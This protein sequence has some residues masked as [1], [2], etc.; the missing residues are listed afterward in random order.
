[1]NTKHTFWSLCEKYDKIEVP[2][3]Q[4]DY[5]QGRE[6]LEA[7]RIRKKFINEY[8]LDSLIKKEKIELDFVYGSIQIAEK[9]ESKQTI[10]IP[11]DGQ[12]R[13]T[14]LFLLHWFVAIKENRLDDAKTNLL[15]FNYET[16]PSAHDFCTKLIE[17]CNIKNL[18]KV[19]QEILDSEWYD[20]EWDNDP[21]I[22]GMIT[23][24][25]TFSKNE[26]FIN[27]SDKFYDSLIG[28]NDGLI[29]FYFI[30]LEEFGLTENLY[31][32]MNARGKM[33]TEF[34]SFKSEFYKII[35]PFPE[36]LEEIKDKIEYAWVENLWA[37]KEK[38]SYVVDKPFMQFLS[39]LTEMLYFKSAK[40]RADSYESDFLDF[41]VLKQIYSKKDNLKFLVFSLDAIKTISELNQ[42]NILWIEKSTIHDILNSILA[43]KRDI[44]QL[45][46]LY[47]TLTYLFQGKNVEYLNDFIRVIRNLIENTTDNSRREWPKLLKSTNNLIQ[48]RNVYEILLDEKINDSLDGFY[49]PQR[50]EEIL[51]A[52]IISSFPAVKELLFSIEDNDI[53]KGNIAMLIAANYVSSESDLADFD[54]TT[55]DIQL[56]KMS[57][58]SSIFDSYKQVSLNDFN[59]IWGDLLTSTLYTQT[60]WSRLTYDNNYS[61]HPAIINFAIEFERSSIKE[62]NDFLVYRRKKF[63]N[64]LLKQ[65]DQFSEIRNVKSQLYLYYIIH[66]NI[67]RKDTT[68]FFKKSGFNFGWL[69]K[70]TG[71]TSIFEKGI[72]NDR[73]FSD[74]NPI[75]QTYSVLFR[76]NCGLN[77]ENTLDEEIVGSGGK[78]DPFALLIEWAN[79]EV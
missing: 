25:D 8:L 24:L 51:K 12:Q 78:K 18:H 35:T 1:M 67:M 45:F 74:I 13:L 54:I 22:S 5:A 38:D 47:A 61:K 60:E 72:E 32:R 19:K 27:H 58:L 75:F 37:Y 59:I 76:Y 70:E 26:K 68:S 6:T 43:G 21:T 7:I 69:A 17:K 65:H 48:D 15:K 44:N 66:M 2:I 73:W 33:L 46:V 40:F 30:S 64:K 57:K 56:F 34:E 39:F 79:S 77:K 23:M 3:I 52:K 16:R 36:I 53:L 29:T 71:F 11:L 62:L 10:F 41:K 14:T 31:I 4:R 50:K 42:E 55:S 20:D 63:I 9:E 49:V 28:D